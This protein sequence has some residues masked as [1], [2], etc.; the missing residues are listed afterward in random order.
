MVTAQSGRQIAGPSRAKQT[1]RVAGFGASSRYSDILLVACSVAVPF[2]VGVCLCPL[3]IGQS[4]H[5]KRGFHR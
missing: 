2:G 4:I 5:Y 1:Q 3:V